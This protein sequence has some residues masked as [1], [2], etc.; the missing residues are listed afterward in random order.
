[1]DVLAVDGRHPSRGTLVSILS[2][3]ACSEKMTE[4]LVLSA[5]NFLLIVRAGDRLSLE[6]SSLLNAWPA[7]R[8][9]VM[10]TG[11]MAYVRT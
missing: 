9:L 4:V 11:G 8:R 1:M 5:E 7:A 10:R 2:Q 6:Y 3:E